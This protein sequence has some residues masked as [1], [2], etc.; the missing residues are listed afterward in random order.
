MR[1]VELL[2]LCA[3]LA[4][5]HAIALPAQL[6]A[7]LP[8]LPPSLQRQL[9]ARDAA[10]TALSADA[11]AALHQ[12]IEA[13][14]ALPA[15]QRRAQRE[16]WQ[17]WQALP[18]D[19][20]LAVRAAALAFAALPADRQQALRAQ[21]AQRDATQRHGWLLGPALGAAFEGLQ[22]LLL[23]VP[24]AQR[25]PLLGALYAMT[26]AERADLVVLAQRTPPQQRDA[27]RRGLLSTSEA[28]RGA[29][30]QAQL[31]R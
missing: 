20:K 10:W 17:A 2:V 6:Q 9:Q 12:R 14:D 26:P 16:H 3:L 11:R 23:Q 19:Q 1:R 4:A 8:Q 15:S 18:A 29:W 21:Y 30:L 22:P 25:A 24:P 31:D 7:A 13:W 27:L 5:A 28:N